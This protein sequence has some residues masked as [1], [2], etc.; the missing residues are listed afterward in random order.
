MTFVLVKGP[1]DE[2]GKLRLPQVYPES[3]IQT[4][5][6]EAADRRRVARLE[7]FNKSSK[8]LAFFRDYLLVLPLLC[9]R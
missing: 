4:I 6:H 1:L 3:T 9:R 7:E 2:H 8:D 5:L